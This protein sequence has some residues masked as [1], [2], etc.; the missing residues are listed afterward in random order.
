MTTSQAFTLTTAKVA[1]LP[2][3]DDALN[4]FKA[5]HS[6]NLATTAFLATHPR[7]AV[8]YAD[9]ALSG[10]ISDLLETNWYAPVPV[11]HGPYTVKHHIYPCN[12]AHSGWFPGLSFNALRDQLINSL[13]NGN[14]NACLKWAVQLYENDA[15]T[16]VDDVTIEWKTPVI[17][18]AQIDIPTQP[19]SFDV[20]HEDTCR[21]MSFSPDFTCPAHEAVGLAQ[22]IR[23]SVYTEMARLR[24][25]YHNQPNRD[26]TFS[27]WMSLGAGPQGQ[28]PVSPFAPHP[29]PSPISALGRHKRLRK[30]RAA[31]SA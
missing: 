10:H 31:K 25:Q 22:E 11:R 14:P 29:P 2:T 20:A 7:I 1:F 30:N 27:D 4:F 6:G 5:V 8:L 24:H 19:G 15:S 26:V 3:L 9:Q 16:P 21:Y 12:A 18:V 17:E 23:R 28:S 13:K